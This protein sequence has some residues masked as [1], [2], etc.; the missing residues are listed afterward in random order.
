[1]SKP[2]FV[3]VAA[4]AV[5]GSPRPAS[6]QAILALGTFD[7]RCGTCH[8]KPADGRTPDRESLSARTPEQILDA[9]TT[10]SMKANAEGLTD[11]QKR[12]LA[13]FIPGRPLGAAVSGQASAMPNRCAAR[14]LGNPLA[15]RAWNGWGAD[16]GNSRY[17]PASAARLS[18]DQIPKLK[19]KWAFGFPNG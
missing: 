2:F 7:Q 12:M 3:C 15:G 9:L 13:E 14:P 5:L 18:A 16:E 11:T 8:T 10:G 17:Q 6:G 4:S 19:L 1:M